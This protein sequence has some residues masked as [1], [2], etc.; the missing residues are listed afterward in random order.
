MRANEVW[1]HS[2]KTSTKPWRHAGARCASFRLPTVDAATISTAPASREARSSRSRADP[3][4]ANRFVIGSVSG[5]FRPL[6]KRA[7]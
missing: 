7:Q 1:A 4:T 6:R 2:R 5:G 3:L